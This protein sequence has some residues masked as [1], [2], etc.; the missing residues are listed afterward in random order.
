MIRDSRD[1]YL[2]HKGRQAGK[3]IGMVLWLFM[4]LVLLGTLAHLL[5]FH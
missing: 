1:G 5:G 4:A 3:G 2:D